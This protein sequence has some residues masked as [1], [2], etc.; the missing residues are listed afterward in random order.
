[1]VLINQFSLIIHLI[2]CLLLDINCRFNHQNVKLDL[3]WGSYDPYAWN[4]SL[5]GILVV[6]GFQENQKNMS[7]IE[8]VE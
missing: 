7:F 3:R 6:S 4:T 8:N 1:M 2:S 5:L